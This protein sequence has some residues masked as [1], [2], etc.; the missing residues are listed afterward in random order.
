MKTLSIIVVSFCA[1]SCSSHKIVSQ[2]PICP[3][4]YDCVAKV[5]TNKSINILED[6]I[7]EKYVRLV[8]NSEYHTIEYTYAYKGKPEIADDGYQ[9]TIYFQVPSSLKKLQVENKELRSLN[10]IIRKSCFCPEAGYELIKIGRLKME[11]KNNS[12]FIDLVFE[13]KKN[14]KVNSIQV[15]VDY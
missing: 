3:K 15:S 5:I 11:K 13:S 7:G 14:M 12:Y 10:L 1:L 9:E 2:K 8:D 4:G 6:S